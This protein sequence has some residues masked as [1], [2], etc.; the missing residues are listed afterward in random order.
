MG[1]AISTFLR[2]WQDFDYIGVA[3]FALFLFSGTFAPVSSFPP[4]LQVVVELTPLYHAV[5]LIRGLTTGT[6]GWAALLHVAYLAALVIVGL[7][8]A[9]RRMGKI[10]CS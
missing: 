1:M 2:T 7:T 10:L 3:I 4:A 8:L 9:S 5:E 6:P